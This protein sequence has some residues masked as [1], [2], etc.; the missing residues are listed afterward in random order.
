MSSNRM[1]RYI[2]TPDQKKNDK[3]PEVNPEVIE[4]YN[5]KDSKFK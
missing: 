1:K 4:I 5:L 3:H 2:N